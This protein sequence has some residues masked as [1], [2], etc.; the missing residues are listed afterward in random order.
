[1]NTVVSTEPRI[2]AVRVTDDEIVAHLVDG[3]VINV[4][5]AWSWRL[6]NVT[7][8]GVM[9]SRFGNGQSVGKRLLRIAV[10]DRGNQPIG[11]AH[12]SIRLTPTRF[13]QA[14]GL[15]CEEC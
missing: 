4:P 5:L 8:F 13:M 11:V 6:A 9:D 7:H 3:R 2:Q 12:S 15:P 10:R 1:M 14:G